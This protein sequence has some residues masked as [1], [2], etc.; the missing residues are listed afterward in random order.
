MAAAVGKKTINDRLRKYVAAAANEHLRAC[1]AESA[2]VPISELLEATEWPLKALQKLQLA[3]AEPTHDDI[4]KHVLHATLVR[5]LQSEFTGEKASDLHGLFDAINELTSIVRGAR[6]RWKALQKAGRR[7]PTEAES[8]DRLIA[9]L[10]H[11]FRVLT[12]QQPTV[13][14]D[15]SAYE[16]YSPF[17]LFLEAFWNSLPA[18]R[19][20]PS[21]SHLNEWARR[22]RKKARVH[23]P[24]KQSKKAPLSSRG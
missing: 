2:A 17:V 4:R 7:I 15:P 9:S 14:S 23:W 21:L 6:H 18:F 20:E 12:H 8:R 10:A 3:L 5:E 19:G 11:A 24:R 13:Q 1:L 22:S 16:Q